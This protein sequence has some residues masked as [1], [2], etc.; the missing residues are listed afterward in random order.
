MPLINVHM[1]KGRTKHQKDELAKA[2]TLAFFDIAGT[3]PE[4][5]QIIFQDVEKEDWAI[6]GKLCE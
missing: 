3:P 5:V 4:S 6:G 1:W 2:I